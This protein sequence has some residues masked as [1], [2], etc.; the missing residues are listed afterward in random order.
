[1]KALT[2]IQKHNN[3]MDRKSYNELIKFN[4]F[5]IVELCKLIALK[6]FIS[7][8][9][10]Y[11]HLFAEHFKDRAPAD[12]EKSCRDK[13]YHAI[14]N[15]QHSIESAVKKLTACGVSPEY[16]ET[17]Y[18]Q[19]STTLHDSVILYLETCKT[20]K[21][22]SLQ[23]IRETLS[24]EC[25]SILNK[26]GTLLIYSIKKLLLDMSKC[27]ISPSELKDLTDKIA[28]FQAD[29]I[30]NGKNVQKVYESLLIKYSGVLKNKELPTIKVSSSKNI[31]NQK[32]SSMNTQANYAVIRELFLLFAEMDGIGNA[33][34]KFY[35][36]LDMSEKD[37]QNIIDTGIA[38]NKKLAEKLLP[39]LFPANM[40]RGDNPSLINMHSTIKNA[41][42]LYIG[43]INKKDREFPNESA[44]KLAR[45]S[46]R[47][48]LR[49]SLRIEL[50]YINR[51]E[52]ITLF[53]PVYSL[54]NAAKNSQESAD[55]DWILFALAHP[56]IVEYSP[57]I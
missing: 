56:E 45:Q 23:K 34:E 55:I 7:V 38:D 44:K 42:S 30:C 49:K 46:A 6:E 11:F 19:T 28:C 27:P 48:S 14:T 3:S 4:L 22:K 26:D 9:D 24:Q 39:F 41:I 13:Y 52:N 31:Y 1:M 21:P 12:I 8:N 53:F 40:F 36:T 47:Q 15:S 37:Y 20:D 54:Y 32:K 18:I 43:V 16:F 51:I 50:F 17:E 35:A 5:L 57:K 2:D 29:T 33:S 25:E 10:V